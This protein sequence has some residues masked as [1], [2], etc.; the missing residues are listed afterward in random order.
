[1]HP[2]KE[3][4]GS[5]RGPVPST[6]SLQ[7][8]AHGYG[9]N[10]NR[11]YSANS[12]LTNNKVLQNAGS[13][14][15]IHQDSGG[16]NEFYKVKATELNNQKRNL[17]KEILHDLKVYSSSLWRFKLRKDYLL[18]RQWTL[19]NELKGLYERLVQFEEEGKGTTTATITPNVVGSVGRLIT[20]QL[21][22]DLQSNLTLVIRKGKRAQESLKKWL[23]RQ[24]PTG[25]PPNNGGATDEIKKT[26]GEIVDELLTS[27]NKKWSEFTTLV[28]C[29]EKFLQIEENL[30]MTRED[31]ISKECQG[32]DLVGSN[33]DLEI[34]IDQFRNKYP[35]QFPFIDK[36]VRLEVDA[37]R[38]AKTFD[39]LVEKLKTLEVSRH[40]N[41]IKIKESFDVEEKLVQELADLQEMMDRLNDDQND[42]E[43][44]KTHHFFNEALDDSG[45]LV[46][47]ELR[48][49]FEFPRVQIN[50]RTDSPVG[51]FIDPEKETPGSHG[52]QGTPSQVSADEELLMK[53]YQLLCSEDFKS[54]LEGG[55]SGGHQNSGSGGKK[56]AQS[57]V[58]GLNEGN[59]HSLS[60]VGGDIEKPT[61]LYWKQTIP[62]NGIIFDIFTK[63]KRCLMRGGEDFK[64]LEQAFCRYFNRK[65]Q[66]RGE[67]SD[68][69]KKYAIRSKEL[70]ECRSSVKGMEERNN[71]ME[72]EREE[73]ERQVSK[74]KTKGEEVVME[75]ERI[76]KQ[77]HEII[78]EEAEA[79]NSRYQLVGS[80][81]SRNVVDKFIAEN[82]EHFNK[83]YKEVR[84]AYDTIEWNNTVREKN[85]CLLADELHVKANEFL[86]DRIEIVGKIQFHLTTLQNL[87]K[88]DGNLALS[89]R[90]YLSGIGCMIHNA[91]STAGFGS[92]KGTGGFYSTSNKENTVSSTSGYSSGPIQGNPAG[93]HTMLIN[94][95]T[96]QLLELLAANEMF[97]G[98]LTTILYGKASDEAFDEG[99]RHNINGRIIQIEFE[100]S[101]V[102][103]REIESLHKNESN[104]LTLKNDIR[105][106]KRTFNEIVVV[107]NELRA[108]L[109][110]A[111]VV[112]VPN[113]ASFDFDCESIDDLMAEA[114]KE[115]IS[116]KLSEM[117]TTT[118]LAGKS[119]RLSNCG[120]FTNGRLNN[121]PK[122]GRIVIDIVD[123]HQEMTPTKEDDEEDSAYKSSQKDRKSSIQRSNTK[124][125]SPYSLQKPPRNL[126]S[127]NKYSNNLGRTSPF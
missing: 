4:Y 84:R 2:R 46:F 87:I 110:S 48:R 61:G 32:T 5:T 111:Y 112:A 96:D 52:F 80:S 83:F 68:I 72:F 10:T 36:L 102:L 45:L 30:G 82:N 108:R 59:E 104:L 118:T 22:Q 71:L 103:E 34:F 66:L 91:T 33:E 122:F 115:Y 90:H 11:K 123:E 106:K 126:P 125:K 92:T 63:M 14:V 101:N 55:I 18:Q 35:T 23:M 17:K 15:S 67:W 39:E 3:G 70:D 41:E 53:R 97:N 119:A 109:G 100:L 94:K 93:G 29:R 117:F 6:S 50:I 24:K 44:M 21:Q 88:S 69:S 79:M 60:G 58:K 86:T 105:T 49:A 28:N 13:N 99:E 89:L 85:K 114:S 98:H 19:M 7:V 64:R 76:L 43:L 120:S 95:S 78:R 107:L 127:G 26:I 20:P 65:I 51:N 124:S 74:V 31:I 54:M 113:E 73:L 1:M 38:G 57:Q 25:A 42:P 37:E 27:L 116:R 75:R 40:E 62:D 16:G 81:K 56:E 121:H 12:A 77:L 8:A 9:S 47:E